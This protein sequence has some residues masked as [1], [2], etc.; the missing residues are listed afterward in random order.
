MVDSTVIL[1]ENTRQVYETALLLEEV[2][3]KS[4]P[5]VALAKVFALLLRGF[6]FLDFGGE[7]EANGN[8]ALGGGFSEDRSSLFQPRDSP[9][10][11][12]ALLR[13]PRTG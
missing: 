12:R 6:L 13:L 2:R 7:S 10:F 1:T 8:F 3:N 5:V 4:L 11:F 9:D